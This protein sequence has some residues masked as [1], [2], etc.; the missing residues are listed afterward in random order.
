M[1]FP[2]DS[3]CAIIAFVTLEYVFFDSFGEFI[4]SLQSIQL[5][6]IWV[7]HYPFLTGQGISS[8]NISVIINNNFNF[9]SLVITSYAKLVGVIC[10]IFSL[11]SI[12]VYFLFTA[13]N[14]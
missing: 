2:V 9:S 13:E 1:N 11:F 10:N 4:F 7:L 3:H 8:D 12:L 14:I 5:I 6:R